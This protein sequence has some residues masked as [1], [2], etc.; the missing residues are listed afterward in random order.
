[1]A[2]LGELILKFIL[3]VLMLFTSLSSF[4]QVSTAIGLS[5]LSGDKKLSITNVKNI[6]GTCGGSV[7][8]ILEVS[9][10]RFDNKEHFQ[11][12]FSG[13]PGLVLRTGKSEFFYRDPLSDFNV[14]QCVTGKDG[15]RLLIASQCGGSACGESYSFSIIDPKT[16]AIFPAKGSKQEC[17][18]QCAS[19]MLGSKIPLQIEA[20]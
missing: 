7:V 12:D 14:V 16:G 1:M 9:G 18:A 10:D 5:P 13:N 2:C 17:D 19:K 20:R 8:A 15:P 11:L 6:Y 3:A 4:A